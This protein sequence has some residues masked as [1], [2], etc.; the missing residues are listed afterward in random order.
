VCWDERECVCMCMCVYVSVSGK[1][2]WKC[3]IVS[4]LMR[5]CVCVCVWVRLKGVTVWLDLSPQTKDGESIK[6]QLR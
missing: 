5:V 2:M 6:R 1:C 3:E 4:V